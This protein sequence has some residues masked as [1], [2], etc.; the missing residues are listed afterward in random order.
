MTSEELLVPIAEIEVAFRFQFGGTEML[1]RN[2]EHSK[3]PV[4]Y[5]GPYLSVDKNKILRG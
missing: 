2:F 3:V 4:N 5:N 1:F